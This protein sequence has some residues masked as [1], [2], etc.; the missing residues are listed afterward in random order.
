MRSCWTYAGRM[1]VVGRSDDF[2]I[3][4]NLYRS[5]RTRQSKNTFGHVAVVL[6]LRTARAGILYKR[7][8]LI[9][10]R[11][12]MVMSRW[13]GSNLQCNLVH[14]PQQGLDCCHIWRHA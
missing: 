10:I 2:A 7:N 3:T 1:L 9:F 12:G 4:M 6:E 8:V 11:W 5:D 13:G 14:H